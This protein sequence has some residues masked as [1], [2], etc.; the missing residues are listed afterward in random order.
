MKKWRITL[1]RLYKLI[2]L[3]L[4]FLLA[5]CGNPQGSNWLTADFANYDKNYKQF[6]IHLLKV[7]QSKGDIVNILGKNYGQVETGPD[8]EI[9]V[10]S[11]WVS[12]IGQ[13]Y[14]DETLTITLVNNKVK[15]LQLSN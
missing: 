9:I 14:I 11:K 15:K 5:G 12:A 6:P 8:Y 1:V 10:Y 7:G 3:S 4:I 13:D 2:A